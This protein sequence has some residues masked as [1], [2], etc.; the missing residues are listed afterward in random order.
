VAARRGPAG[1]RRAEPRPGRGLE[2][3]RREAIYQ[4]PYLEK[5]IKDGAQLSR[6]GEEVIVPANFD[7]FCGEKPVMKVVEGTPGGQVHSGK[8]A[9]LL[10]GGIYLRPAKDRDFQAREGDGLARLTCFHP[11]PTR[12]NRRSPTAAALLPTRRGPS[13]LRPIAKTA[14][15]HLSAG[16]R[17]CRRCPLGFLPCHCRIFFVAKK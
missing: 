13:A 8:R 6:E 16:P 5:A 1:R 2:E 12:P 7:Q 9:L 17:S 10:R 4:T 14:F 3:V 15:F 11:R